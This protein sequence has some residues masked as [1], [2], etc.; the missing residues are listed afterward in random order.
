MTDKSSGQ[1]ENVIFE[2]MTSISAVIKSIELKK[3][4]RRILEVFFDESKTRSKHAELCFLKHKSQQMGFILTPVPKEFIDSKTSGSSHGGIIALCTPRK[5]TVL[6]NDNIIPDGLYI[7]IEGIED[8]YNFGYSLRSAYAA[9]A[10]AVILSPRNWMNAAGAVARSSAGVSELLDIYISEPIDAVD[11]FKSMNYKIVCA[12]IRDSIS[13]Y[14]ANLKKP[15]FMIV[16][17]EKRGISRSLLTL[18]D[19]VVRIDYGRDF[20]GSLPSASALSVIAFEIMRQNK[21]K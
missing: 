21:L 2:G 9:G 4:N 6:N 12:G 5:H 3:S 20:S 11:M 16:G 17:G 10:D 7:Y 18:A 15:I 1:C 14:D 19:L 13:I 8:P